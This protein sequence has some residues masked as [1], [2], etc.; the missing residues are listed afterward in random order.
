MVLRSPE[1]EKRLTCQLLIFD[2]TACS[3]F[4]NE[5]ILQFRYWSRGRLS[6]KQPNTTSYNVSLLSTPTAPLQVFDLAI[7]AM[8]SMF[9]QLPKPLQTDVYL[10]IPMRVYRMV[11]R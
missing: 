1:M 11:S 7:L 3:A 9:T 6:R 4:D 8:R 10:R 2:L 5:I